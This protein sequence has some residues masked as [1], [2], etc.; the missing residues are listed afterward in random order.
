LAVRLF[1]KIWKP[2]EDEIE[3]CHLL[4]IAPD[5]AL[6]LISFAGLP[7]EQGRYLSEEF[8][9]HYLSSGRDAIWL[10]RRPKKG[11]NLLALGDPDY[12]ASALERKTYSRGY[13]SA[14]RNASSDNYPGV[15]D[16][17]R[18]IRSNCLQLSESR[19]TRLP[20]T[21]NEVEQIAG[22][23]NQNHSDTALW[24]L[25][26]EA[27]EDNLK[28]YAPG[29]R[30]IHIATH[31]YFSPATCRREKY[32]AEPGE[33]TGP[34]EESPLLQS[35]LLLAGSNL[36]GEMADSLEVDD[37]ILTAEEVSILDLTGVEWVVLSACESGLGEVESG[38]GVYGLRRAFQMAGART[39]ISSLWPIADKST[40]EFMISLYEASNQPLYQKI[41]QY[42]KAQIDKLRS[43]GYS[44][45]PYQWAA[46]IATG[47]WR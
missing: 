21:R 46:F 26:K 45:H 39:V 31:G 11:E 32:S 25:D 42:Q 13:A 20:A 30:N 24:F 29:K 23:W 9:I 8:P 18:N 34:I 44:D 28:R 4:L 10:N 37:G 27:T 36:H 41:Y 1:D 14:E 12:D 15:L 19:V 5:G 40:A 2:I 16:I 17:Q 33:Y 7:N 47:D 35:G 3:G 6:D 22:Y 38:E 43:H